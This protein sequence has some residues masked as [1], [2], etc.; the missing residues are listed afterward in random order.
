MNTEIQEVQGISAHKIKYTAALLI[1]AGLL[2]ATLSFRSVGENN[3]I[4]ILVSIGILM[5]IGW[6]YKLLL[7]LPGPDFRGGSVFLYC[8]GPVVGWV[9]TGLY[10]LYFIFSAAVD[11]RNISN[12][13][14]GNMLPELN[15]FVMPVMFALVMVYAVRRGKSSIASLSFIIFVTIATLKLLAVVLQLPQIEFENYLPLFQNRAGTLIQALFYCVTVPMGK[16][17]LLLFLLP[18]RT[19]KA[20]VPTA[21]TYILGILTGGLLMLIILLRDIGVLGVLV[22]YMNNTIFESV[23][24]LDVFGFLSRIEIVFIFTFSITTMFNISLCCS[25]SSELLS[26]A[27]HLKN[28]KNF[29]AILGVASAI[30]SVGYFICRT[31]AELGVIMKNIQPYISV[32]FLIL[33]PA[34]ALL[35]GKIKEQTRK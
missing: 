30:F 9:V 34:A 32:W 6:M 16:I 26:R 12:V 15:V 2:Q 24:L 33:I 22:R 23:Q 7:F 14:S 4:I 17:A 18:I 35:T 25:V 5:L 13:I 31:A 20:L 21:R 27:L 1:M 10:L 19:E 28:L 29:W 11:L 8:F 3:G